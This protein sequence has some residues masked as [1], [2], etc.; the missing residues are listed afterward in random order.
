MFEE[1][2][3]FDYETFRNCKPIKVVGTVT[4]RSDVANP[5]RQHDWIVRMEYSKVGPY[6]SSHTGAY[7]FWAPTREQCITAARR[8]AKMDALS[9][10]G[11]RDAKCL[12]LVFRQVKMRLDMPDGILFLETQFDGTITEEWRGKHG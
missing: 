5:N 11:C 7:S 6:I 3:L 9:M 4:V 12:G 10:Y 2:D 8:L 1:P